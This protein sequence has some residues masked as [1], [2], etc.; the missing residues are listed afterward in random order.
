MICLRILFGCIDATTVLS[1]VIA[2]LGIFS[3]ITLLDSAL[4]IMY[5]NAMGPEYYDVACAIKKKNLL[6]ACLCPFYFLLLL[7]KWEAET[8]QIK[9]LILHNWH[10]VQHIPSKMILREGLICIIS[11]E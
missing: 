8:L 3:A 2:E 1:G 7:F 4:Q 11:S 6:V 10:H 5:P 9:H